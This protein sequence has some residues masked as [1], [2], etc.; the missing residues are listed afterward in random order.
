MTRRYRISQEANQGIVAA[1]ILERRL[2][3]GA[4]ASRIALIRELSSLPVRT[5]PLRLHRR[6]N[7]RVSKRELPANPTLAQLGDPVDVPSRLS[8]HRHYDDG[9]LRETEDAYGHAM[10]YWKDRVVTLV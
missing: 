4:P 1:A 8:R 2:L 10:V 5:G 9:V 3:R 6:W 7:S